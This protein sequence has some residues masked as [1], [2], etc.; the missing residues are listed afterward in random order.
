MTEYRISFLDIDNELEM[1]CWAI[2]NCD[3]FIYKTMKDIDMDDYFATLHQF[4]F[5]REQ[6]AMWFRLH[7]S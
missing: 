2:N 3:S 7:W 6:D 5:L 4:Y 1:V